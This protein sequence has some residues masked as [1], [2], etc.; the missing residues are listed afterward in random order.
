M[1][2]PIADVPTGTGHFLFTDVEGSTRL[3]TELSSGYTETLA[4]HRFV[5]RLHFAVVLLR[6][7]NGRQGGAQCATAC[8]VSRAS[9]LHAGQRK[10]NKY[11][12]KHPSDPE[13]IRHNHARSR[14]L[15][16]SLQ[17]RVNHF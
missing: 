14:A 4:E 10:A 3:L 8:S 17:T 11:L 2:F 9:T 1:P 6:E 15:P 7:P 13:P 16:R 12:R 5:L